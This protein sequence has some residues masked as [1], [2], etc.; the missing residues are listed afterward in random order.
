MTTRDFVL[1]LN[2]MTT[3]ELVQEFPNTFHYL[4]AS[5]GVEGTANKMIANDAILWRLVKEH[6]KKENHDQREKLKNV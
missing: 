5:D 3:A 2:S 1:W 4:N 6:A